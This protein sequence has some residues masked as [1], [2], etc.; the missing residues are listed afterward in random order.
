MVTLIL[1]PSVY[2]D[3]YTKTRP[4]PSGLPTSL[5]YGGAFFDV[6]LSASDLSDPSYLSNTLV[7]VVRV[8]YS[9]HAMNMG[10]RYL[11]LNNTYTSNS[12][13]SATLHVSQM[14]PCVACFPP[15]PAFIF[16]VVNGVPSNGAMVMV[17]TGALG[18]QPTVAAAA[19]PGTLATWNSSTSSGAKSSSNS[20]K[21]SPSSRNLPNSA[22]SLCL[23]GLSTLLF[24]CSL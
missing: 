13:G 12:D 14:P 20:A 1:L 11:Q 24:I 5:S 18:T 6:K 7:S 16:V 23:L 10:Q 22:I 4:K 3:Y 9:T 8:G 17:G 15:G 21:K 19:L 2:P